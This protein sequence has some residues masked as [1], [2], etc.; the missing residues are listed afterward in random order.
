MATT[1]VQMPQ[2]LADGPR[3]LAEALSVPDHNTVF[4]RKHAYLARTL[5]P[6]DF[7]NLEVLGCKNL[8]L[9]GD[10]RMSVRNTN[11]V[12]LVLSHHG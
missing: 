9:L 4:V 11:R 8:A 3:S 2:A 10:C 6:L 12:L 5:C 7:A 1:D